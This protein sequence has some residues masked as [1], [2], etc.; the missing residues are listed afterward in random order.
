MVYTE[1]LKSSGGNTGEL[2]DNHDMDPPN[3]RRRTVRL[4]V[5]DVYANLNI[6]PLEPVSDLP[7]ILYVSSKSIIKQT[8]DVV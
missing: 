5:V 1:A 6:V 7:H 2:G 4:L 8:A 3:R